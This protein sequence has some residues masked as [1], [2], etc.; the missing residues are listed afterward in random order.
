MQSQGKQGILAPNFRGRAIFATL[1]VF[2]RPKS[3]RRFPAPP[4]RD[5]P[6]P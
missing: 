5:K 6:A 1:A 2:V 3:A 4:K